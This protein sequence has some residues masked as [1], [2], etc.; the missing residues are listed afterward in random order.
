MH[1]KSHV[2]QLKKQV[3]TSHYSLDTHQEYVSSISNDVPAQKDQ[4]NHN[5]Y[6]EGSTQKKDEKGSPTCIKLQTFIYSTNMTEKAEY[7]S[8]PSFLFT[9][10][11]NC[12]FA[13]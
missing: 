9:V 10:Y 11:G 12:F 8:L 5:I 7:E 4:R 2:K 6:N 3:I 13:M 1:A